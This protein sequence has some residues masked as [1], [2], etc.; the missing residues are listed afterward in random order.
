MVQHQKLIDRCFWPNTIE[1]IMDNLRKED[2]PIAKNMLEKMEKN[3][4]LSMKLA[5]KMLRDSKNQ[6]FGQVLKTELNVALHKMEDQDFKIGV[7]QVLRER[8]R[9]PDF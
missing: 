8:N 6:C 1:E 9:N 3:S 2:H 5:L 4:M 7:Q